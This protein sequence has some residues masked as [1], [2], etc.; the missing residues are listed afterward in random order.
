MKLINLA[1]QNIGAFNGITEIDFSSLGEIF[2]IS[3]NTGSG[4]TTIFDA[5]TFA[6]YGKLPGSRS[7]LELKRFR[8]D[9]AGDEEE[10]FVSLI[11][12]INQEKYKVF[13]S[14]PQPYIKR[15]G[16]QGYKN[17]A[18]SLHKQEELSSTGELN[19]SGKDEWSILCDSIDAIKEN[20]ETLIGLNCEEFSRIVLLPQGEFADFLKLSSNERKEALGKLFPIGLYSSIIAAAKDKSSQYKSKIE[21]LEK[22]ITDLR[23]EYNEEQGEEQE[24]EINQV[25]AE[26]KKQK[27]SYTEQL[28]TNIEEKQKYGTLLA[29]IENRNAHEKKLSLLMDKK[30]EIDG[31]V[32][33]VKNARQALIL[34]SEILNTQNAQKLLDATE[35]RE[36]ILS[37]QLEEADQTY[38]ALEIE[39]PSI[40]KLKNDADTIAFALKDIQEGEEASLIYNELI[41]KKEQLAQELQKKSDEIINLQNDIKILENKQQNYSLLEKKYSS[42]IE[43]QFEL[44]KKL[45][46]IKDIY[47]KC[48]L[49]EHYKK[50]ILT[51]QLQIKESAA[52]KDVLEKTITTAKKTLADFETEKEE[53]LLRNE[54]YSLAQ[55]LEEGKP[56]PVCGSKVHPKKAEEIHH[57]APLDEKIASQK[58][59]LGIAEEKLQ[60]KQS[61][62]SNF[63]GQLKGAEENLLRI[64]VDISLEEAEE[65]KTTT[66]ALVEQCNK[67]VIEQ[68]TAKLEHDENDKKLSLLKENLEPIQNETALIQNAKNLTEQ[69]IIR[70]KELFNKKINT[71]RDLLRS[72]SFTDDQLDITCFSKDILYELTKAKENNKQKV[73]VFKEKLSSIEEQRTALSAQKKELANTLSLRKKEFQE[74]LSLL[75]KSL[76]KTDFKTI[77]DAQAAFIDETQILRLEEKIQAWNKERDSL[78]SLIENSR[79]NYPHSYEDIQNKL[80]SCE[81]AVTSHK[82]SIFKIEQ[83]LELRQ[84][85]RI[86]LENTKNLLISYDNELRLAQEEGGKYI[87]LFMLLSNQNPKKTPL[88]AWVLGLYLE[89]ITQ[90][91]SSRLN[92]I[93]DGRYTLLLKTEDDGGKDKIKG[94]DLEIFDSYTGKKRPCATLSGGETFMASI[95]LALALTDVVQS[96]A[97]GVSLDSLFIDE[98]FGSLDDASLEKALS[99]LDEIREKRMVGLIS[100]VGDLR[101]RISSQILVTKGQNGSSITIRT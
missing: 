52:D 100:H 72:L 23:K 74:A 81:A 1:M 17:S 57:T 66:Q 76:S 77:E 98:G 71:H 88:D 60:T 59:I 51:L 39:K 63:E 24:K 80:Q 2:L 10:A 68:K 54:A 75:E 31:T 65:R 91:A 70:S 3:G 40:L 22:R 13:R 61:Q 97:G 94:L 90:Y 26:L 87:K 16:T 73:A 8:S 82:E 7:S 30:S 93:S 33:I 79:K 28:N 19:F 86:T 41:G 84:Q 5:V 56:C 58:N 69:D 34:H 44:E 92:R 29:E 15:D 46:E 101:S 20:I 47:E 42:S 67:D 48:V 43:K 14:L 11:F 6:L 64:T 4:K 95:S 35:Q 18:A 12:S 32:S 9:F 78:L 85:E 49:K 27:A 50:E 25:I 96:K 62:L 53:N 37:E 83:A 89:E 21:S 99:I 36:K 38:T 45:T 55:K